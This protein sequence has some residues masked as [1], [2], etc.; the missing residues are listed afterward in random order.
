MNL[1]RGAHDL[2]MNS[3]WGPYSRRVMAQDRT[4]RW[5]GLR[6]D[7]PAGVFHPGLFFSSRFVVRALDKLEL[8]GIRV[9]DVGCGSGVLGIAAAR[10]GATVTAV[11]INPAAVAVTGANARR[12]NVAVAA[13]ESDL[14]DAVDGETFDLILVNPPYFAADPTDDASRAFFAGA[15]FEYFDRFFAQIRPHLVGG[16]RVLMVLSGTCDLDAI[17]A[18]A[19]GQGSELR[20]WRR[21]FA[22]GLVENLLFDVVL[23]GR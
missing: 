3:V 7:V 9:L 16:A 12:N 13:L 17:G 18:S 19:G 11:D 4:W 10:A 5:R 20:L 15:G 8:A 1:R 21:R 22:L 6:L 23:A 14:L 2:V